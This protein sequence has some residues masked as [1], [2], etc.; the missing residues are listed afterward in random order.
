MDILKLITSQL[1]NANTLSQMG[2]SVGAD[3][4]QVKKL[5][6]IGLPTLL[7]GLNRNASTPQGAE[8]LA[9]VLDK[10][11]DDKIDDL[12]SFF[13]KV[14]VRDGAKILRH[15]FSNK[16]DMVHNNLAEQ[17]GLNMD[18]VSKLMSQFAPLIIG[19][20]A[21]QKK[22]Q[23]LDSNGVA[24]LTSS[25]AKM[26]GQSDGGNLMSMATKFLDS[27]NDGDI[28]DDIGKLIGGLFKK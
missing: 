5:V 16:N 6:Q 20:L 3:P 28:K 22:T 4:S 24:N 26:M 21:N 19:A 27:N 8:H 12:D 11:Q 15:V 10:H 14:D 25:L 18:Q 17:T 9:G 7:E 2:N 23:N 13:G 1:E